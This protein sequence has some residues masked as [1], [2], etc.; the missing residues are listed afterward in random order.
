MEVSNKRVG[1][2]VNEGSNQSKQ[3]FNRRILNSLPKVPFDWMEWWKY[4]L[5]PRLKMLGWHIAWNNIVPISTIMSKTII[6]FC[7]IA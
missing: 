1:W 2:C 6:T 5:P 7:M 3:M 4:H